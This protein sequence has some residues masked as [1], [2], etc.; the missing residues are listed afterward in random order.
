MCCQSVRYPL[1]FSPLI[2]VLLLCSLSCPRQMRS[3]YSTFSEDKSASAPPPAT[4]FNRPR[5][6]VRW[7]DYEAR[8]RELATVKERR[9][10]LENSMGPF[11]TRAMDLSVAFLN[12][13]VDAHLMARQLNFAANADTF[14]GVRDCLSIHIAIAG[15]AA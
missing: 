14:V 1:H 10:A 7:S 4:V 12:A 5:V 15:T 8:R 3:I 2:V 9:Q 13:Q 6:A 11:K